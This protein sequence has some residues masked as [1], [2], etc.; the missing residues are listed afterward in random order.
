MEKKENNNPLVGILFAWIDGSCMGLWGVASKKLAQY[1]PGA[2]EYGLVLMVA[3]LGHLLLTRLPLDKVTAIA[4]QINRRCGFYLGLFVLVSVAQFYL[5]VKVYE[6]ENSDVA[7]SSFLRNTSLI[8]AAMIA[9]F[10][11]NTGSGKLGVSENFK[12]FVRA[13]LNTIFSSLWFTIGIWIFFGLP[14]GKADGID[15]FSFWILGSVLIGF[16]RTVTEYLVAYFAKTITKKQMNSVVGMCLLVIG[17]LASIVNWASRVNLGYGYLYLI[18][19]GA[20][21]PVM[22]AFRFTALKRMN[23]LLGKKGHTIVAYLVSSMILG[24]VFFGESWH[25]HRIVGLLIGLTAIPML[26]SGMK[27][28]LKLYFR[29]VIKA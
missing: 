13:G 7:T 23:D 5:G 29:K 27:V 18:A 24:V 11:T 9:V 3:G 12:N 20:I 17:L 1:D 16:F 15:Y 10:R 4:G 26:D 22:Q 8:F 25:W 2:F 21:I 6:D 19:V 14:M 28:E